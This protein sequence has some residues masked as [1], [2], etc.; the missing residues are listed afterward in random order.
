MVRRKDS[1][2]EPHYSGSGQTL[3]FAVLG[4]AMVVACGGNAPVGELRLPELHPYDCAG[5]G[6][7]SPPSKLILHPEGI[8]GSYLVVLTASAGDLHT[9]ARE[10]ARKHGGTIFAEWS[11]IRAF[12]VT[13]PDAAASALSEEP[14][15]C[16]VEQD[17]WGS[18]AS[19]R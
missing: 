11:S 8:S 18:A 5:G 10:L 4:A 3:V 16:W 12:G 19:P 2:A 7:S 1:P 9:T 17:Q 13:L 6:G 15:V 14:R